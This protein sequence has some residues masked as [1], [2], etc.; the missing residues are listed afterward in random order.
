MNAPIKGQTCQSDLSY[1]KFGSEALLKL[2]AVFE[3]Q[4]DGV[5]KNDDIEYVHKTRVTSRRLRA[6]IASFQ[7]IVFP[8][9][10]SRNGYAKSRKSRVCL[11]KQETLMCK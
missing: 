11:V 2:L 3:D 8:E 10:N 9:K 5:I 6:T 7:S 4:I 1:C